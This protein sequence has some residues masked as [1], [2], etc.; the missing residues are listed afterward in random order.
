MCKAAVTKAEAIEYPDFEID[1]FGKAV[2]MPTI[3]EIE[4]DE[5]L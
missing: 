5:T 4:K 2:T 1:T 3:E